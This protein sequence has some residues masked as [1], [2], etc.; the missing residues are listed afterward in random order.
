MGCFVSLSFIFVLFLFSFFAP[1][2]RSSS[3]SFSCI[4]HLTYLPSHL[5]TFRSIDVVIPHSLFRTQRFLFVS[6]LI[7]H[8][9]FTFTPFIFPR[10]FSS[11]KL[12]TYHPLLLY[13]NSTGRGGF[14]NHS[15]AAEPAVE[16]HSVEHGVYESTGRGEVGNIVH[17]TRKERA[18]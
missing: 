8:S 14:A 12:I 1:R 16:H 4:Y 2:H 9:T 3:P 10:F 17:D 5:P 18:D 11:Y 6:L 7:L 13:S 15:S